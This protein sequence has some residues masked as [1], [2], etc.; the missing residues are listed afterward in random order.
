NHAT[1]CSVPRGFEESLLPAGHDVS[2]FAALVEKAAARS[3]PRLPTGVGVCLYIRRALLDD[4]GLFDAQ[5]FGLGYGEENDFCMRA[6]ARGWLNLVDDATFIYHAGHRSFGTTRQA[7]ERRGGKIL[8]RLHPR[9]MAT[10][11]ELMRRD[12]L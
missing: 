12:P 10:I 1:L 6:L 2:S 4:I 9:Y 8:R 7:Q 3:Y 5:R 11:A